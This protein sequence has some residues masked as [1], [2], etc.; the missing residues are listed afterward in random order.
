MVSEYETR[1]IKKESYNTREHNK[2]NM[3]YKKR[4]KGMVLSLH[5]HMKKKSFKYDRHIIDFF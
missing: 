1:C 3:Q 4:S 5:F 2:Q